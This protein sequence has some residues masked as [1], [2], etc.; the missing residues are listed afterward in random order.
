[1]KIDFN[2]HAAA[3]AQSARGPQV[4]T[5]PPAPEGSDGGVTITLSQAAQSILKNSGPGKSGDSPAH[6][7]AAA[8]EGHTGP[9]GQLVKTFTPGYVA[10]AVVE[11]PAP[12]DSGDTGATTETG[13]TTDTGG[14]T[15]TGDTTVAEGS[16]GATDTGTTE[17]DDTTVVAAPEAGEG[18]GIGETEPTVVVEEPDIAEVLDDSAPTDGETSEPESGMAGSGDAV[19]STGEGGTSDGGTIGDTAEPVAVADTGDATDELLDLLDEN[20]DE[21]V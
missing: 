7:A 5:T 3:Q 12:E 10:P 17:G 9:F 13:E 19:A 2:P 14:T 11:D 21:V 15:E 18:S 6:M 4:Q 8:A 16:D 1:M 20:S